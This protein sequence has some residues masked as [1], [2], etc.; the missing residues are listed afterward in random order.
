MKM[1]YVVAQCAAN[2]VSI[3]H[4]LIISRGNLEKFSPVLLH[5]MIF[6]LASGVTIPRKLA[7]SDP[8]CKQIQKWLRAY[9][10]RT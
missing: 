6:G 5:C 9:F 8:K 1:T 7:T 10:V 3:Y 2:V 4:Y